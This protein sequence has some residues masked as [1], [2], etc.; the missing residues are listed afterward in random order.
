MI[1]IIFLLI[2]GGLTAGGAYLL[3]VHMPRRSPVDPP[4]ADG[5]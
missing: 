4:W 5:L 1:W 2:L 3:F